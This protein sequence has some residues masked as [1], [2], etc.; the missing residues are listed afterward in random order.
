LDLSKKDSNRWDDGKLGNYWSNQWYRWDNN[1]DEISEIPY[2]IPISLSADR[3][4]LMSSHSR[5]KKVID[6]NKNLSILIE[7]PVKGCLYLSNQKIFNGFKRTWLFSLKMKPL[8]VIAHI[9]SD[10]TID[11]VKVYI[12]YN[13]ENPFDIDFLTL[14]KIAENKYS[15]SLTKNLIFNHSL[16]FIVQDI[17]GHISQSKI[18]VECFYFPRRK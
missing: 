9:E 17:Y 11:K 15:C 4:P 10:Y 16:T 12:D 14:K 18:D 7:K 8:D 2:I 1:K 5:V 13:Y 6:I 3:H